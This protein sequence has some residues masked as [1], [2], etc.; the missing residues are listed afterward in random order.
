VAPTFEWQ[1][2]G[3]GEQTIKI[4]SGIEGIPGGIRLP[5]LLVPFRLVKVA[6][7]PMT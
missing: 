6:M 2:A 5:N 4:A 1:I 7:T 3:I